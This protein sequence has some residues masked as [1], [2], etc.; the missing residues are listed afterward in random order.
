MKKL[1]YY[2]RGKVEI[3]RIKVRKRQTLETLIN[4][5]LYYSPYRYHECEK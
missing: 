2:F 3:P 5:E 4:E 1:N